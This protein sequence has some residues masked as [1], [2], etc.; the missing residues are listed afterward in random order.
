[1]ARPDLLKEEEIEKKLKQVPLWQRDGKIITRELSGANF[2]ATVGMLNAV[3]VL[4]DTMDH[5]PD[6]LIYGWNKL[7]V[8]LSTHDRGGLTHLDF[9]LAKKIDE[10]DF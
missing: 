6:M 5:H 3:A 2:A 4:A 9:D 10:L 7:R 8:S 1:M